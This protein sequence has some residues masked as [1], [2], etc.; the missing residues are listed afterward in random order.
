[1][2]ELEKIKRELKA[3]RLMRLIEKDMMEDNFTMCREAAFFWKGKAEA[4]EKENG[5]LKLKE[6]VLYDIHAAL[7]IKWGDDPYHVISE[8]RQQVL[9]LEQQVKD[10]FVVYGQTP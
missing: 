9:Q 3:E 4:L 2:S 1:M 7:G 10:T 5:V 8:L 6:Q